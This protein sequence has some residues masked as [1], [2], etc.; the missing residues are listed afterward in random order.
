MSTCFVSSMHLIFAILFTIVFLVVFIDGLR[1]KRERSYV[2]LIGCFLITSYFFWGWYHHY[3]ID[4]NI[5]KV[6]ELPVTEVNYKTYTDIRAKNYLYFYT[7]NDKLKTL[8]E[9]K[10]KE[11]S[12]FKPH[13]E[14]KSFDSFIKIVFP[15]IG[16]FF[17]GVIA[18]T[19]LYKTMSQFYIIIRRRYKPCFHSQSRQHIK[20]IG[21]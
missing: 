4:E 7:L 8:L 9:K 5:K 18:A 10:D 3:S 19:L 1:N 14:V 12:V 17:I 6:Q 11:F 20:I 16:V 15:K 13:E 21:G 2:A